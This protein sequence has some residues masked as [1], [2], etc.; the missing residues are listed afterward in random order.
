MS[1]LPILEHKGPYGAFR[2]SISTRMP[3]LVTPHRFYYSNSRSSHSTFHHP[4]PQC[5]RLRAFWRGSVPLAVGRRT[6]DL[7]EPELHAARLLDPAPCQSTVGFFLL[8]LLLAAAFAAG[9]ATAAG[10]LLLLVPG[11]A[12]AESPPTPFTPDCAFTSQ[13]YNTTM[14]C[15]EVPPP[16]CLRLPRL[17][18]C[19]SV[20]AHM[21]P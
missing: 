11:L 3:L 20:H 1:A 19:I 6:V 5:R 10:W 18:L 21:E 4:P 16:S 9:P 12:L 2:G 17:R 15:L 14:L 8:W 7:R 13:M